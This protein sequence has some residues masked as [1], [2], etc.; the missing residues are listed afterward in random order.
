MEAQVA[1]MDTN[2]TAP[3]AGGL[4][5]EAPPAETAARPS[6]TIMINYRHEDVSFAASTLYRE[7]KGR[8]GR[9]NIFFDGGT[10]EPGMQFFEA[11]KSH[12]SGTPGAFLALIGPNWLP[13]MDSHQRRGDDDYVVKEI[14]LGL[15]HGWTVIPVLL[16]DAR[17]PEKS[18]LPLAIRELPGYQV[19][20]LRETSLDDDI[21]RLAVRLDEISAHPAEEAETGDGGAV[22]TEPPNGTGTEAVVTAEVPPANDEH[23]QELIDEAD[24]LVIFLGA[25]ANT[26][27][28]DGPFRPGESMLP[29]DTDLAEYLAVK[30]RLKSEQREL[31]E[32]AQYARMI[33]GEP[34][35]FKWVRSMFVNSAPGPIH[36]YLAGLP[37]RLEKLGLEKR[38]QMI[39][40]SKFDVALE[41][42]FLEIKEPF[43]VA[44]FMAPGTEHAGR[45]VHLKWRSNNL[46]PILVPNAY[47]EFP[48]V[49]DDS[50]LTRTVIV[51]ING[52]IDDPGIGYIWKNNYVITEDHYIDYLAR[53]PAEEV[54]PMQILTKLRQASCL[55]LGYTLADWRLRVFLHWIWPGQRPSG[56]THWAVERSPD[57]LE[58]R[59]W[60]Q[61]G[62]GLYRSRLTDYVQGFDRF[63]VRNRDELQ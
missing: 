12:L 11:I 32:V 42:A 39:V 10:L 63:L 29:D 44:L 50:Q 18:D 40:T 43:D 36:R 60:Q 24:N 48:I 26:D 37:T 22:R 8:F 30:A 4:T 9:Q 41:Q 7:L 53:R 46:Q 5:A 51:R 59:F 2:D 49:G 54:V 33:K 55:F 28:H 6:L 56:A 31:A 14:E 27:D 15:Q 61:N 57:M 25:G 21:D 19:A 13:T 38:Y 45:F 3:G 20:H 34:N 16:N 62:V 52:A 47:N 17:L 23:Y 58:R 35:V 1:G